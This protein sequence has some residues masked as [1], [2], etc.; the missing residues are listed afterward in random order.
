MKK[1]KTNPEPSEKGFME[2]PDL[3]PRWPLCPVKNHKRDFHDVKAFGVL[4]ASKDPRWPNEPIMP[5]IVHVNLWSCAGKNLQA[6]LDEN[7][8]TEYASLDALVA[9]GWVVD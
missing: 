8:K 5:V 4:I 2:N 1:L 7:A 9:D 6:I 3:W